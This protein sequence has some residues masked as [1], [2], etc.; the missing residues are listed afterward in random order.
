[1]K[2]QHVRKAKNRKSKRSIRPHNKSAVPDRPRRTARG[3]KGFLDLTDDLFKVL[4]ESLQVGVYIV[5]EEV[6]KYVNPAALKLFGYSA[7]EVIG[8]MGVKDFVVPEEAEL[9]A[10]NIQRRMSGE[11]QLYPNVYRAMT[12]DKRII[13][14]ETSGS[15]TIYKGK[16]AVF[17]SVMDITERKKAEQQ[18]VE[19]E[20]KFRTLAEASVVG[21]Y[22]FQDW[23]YKY[24]NP[25]AAEIMGYSVEETAGKLSPKDIVVP[26]DMPFLEVEIQKR[27]S[28]EVPSMHYEVRAIRKD[29]KIIHCE[30]YDSRIIYQGRTAIMG[31]FADITGRKEA[32]EKLRESEEK[33]KILAEASLIG[34]Y[35]I[36]D[37]VFRYINPVFAKMSGYTREEVIDK[38]SPEDVVFPGDEPLIKDSRRR[39]LSGEAESTNYKF[40]LIKKN[41]EVID[42]EVYSSFL[43]YKGKPAIVGSMLDITD[44]NRAVKE[45]E[46][47]QAKLFQLQKMEALG[48]LAGGVAHDLNSL[49]TVIQGYAEL[50]LMR[51]EIDKTIPL[52]MEE[53]VNAAAK[54]TAITQQLLMFGRKHPMQPI[55]LNINTIINDFQDM[56]SRLIGDNIKIKTDLEQGLWT[57]VAD[58]VSIERIIMNL[59]VNARDAI[60]KEGTIT[61]ETR[62]IDLDQIKNINFPEVHSG[63]FICLTVTDTG[64]G[65]D[66]ETVQHMFEPFF[67][68]KEKGTGLGL[69]VVHGIIKQHGGWMSVHSKPGYGTIFKSYLPAV[70]TKHEEAAE[71]AISLK[72]LA[73]NG[74]RLLVV[75]DEALIMD[76]IGI[77]LG[78]NGYKVFPAANA[79]DAIKLFK[80]EYGK[81]DLVFSDVMLPGKSG[82]ELVEYLVSEKPDLK[83]ILTS[84]YIRYE[85]NWSFIQERS[86]P[87]IQKPYAL[88]VLLKTIKDVLSDKKEH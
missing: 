31:S 43:M 2:M 1:M 5:Q 79:E 3:T 30:V 62:N 52:N 14:F 73:G 84:G 68:T 38:M 60:L 34:V 24:V 39:L 50:G 33:F 55:P 28:G 76:F 75:E 59:V 72:E 10:R 57:V 40:R 58:K 85:S 53:I 11:V 7:E 70:P 83:F 46:D 65:M 21:V 67:T 17:G 15:R 8:R 66:D 23:I 61:L 82:I 19:S 22:I 44:R 49:L 56:F 88:Q 32:E 45:K 4:T 25:K 41:K 64:T 36:Q 13:Y 27:L 18:L 78:E 35:L 42:V 81:F 86:Y 37:K 63:S 54:G 48:L 87:F 12:K 77:A 6:I 9:A 26:E 74:E 29:K 69:S 51:K 71:E 80:Q 16:P 20:E 47:M